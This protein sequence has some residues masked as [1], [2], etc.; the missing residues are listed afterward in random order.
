VVTDAFDDAAVLAAP[1][2]TAADSASTLASLIRADLAGD[3][4]G[5]V[6][7]AFEGAVPVDRDALLF[8]WNDAMDVGGLG[9]WI[10]ADAGLRGRA[11]ELVL[12]LAPP[13]PSPRENEAALDAVRAY[14]GW[15]AFAAAVLVVPGYT[16]LGQARPAPGLHP[17]AEQRV[18]LAVQ[19]FHANK[20]PFILASGGAVHPSGTPYVEALEM[21]KALLAAGVPAER[22]L[23][24]ARARHSTTNL[25]NAGRIMLAAGMRRALIATVGGG[26]FG[27]DV[28]GQDF[29]FSNPMISTFYARCQSELGYRVGDLEDGGD[30]LVAFVPAPDAT[31]V[32]FRDVLDP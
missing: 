12:C 31:R 18:A 19:S 15:G 13:D 28:F 14:T 32:G 27:S 29:Y 26:L 21:K 25:R 23:V 4:P 8:A 1:T 9:D 3:T 22:L 30:G 10:D 20:A 5:A 17:V 6:L 11:Q 2:G 24:D 7:R 16:P